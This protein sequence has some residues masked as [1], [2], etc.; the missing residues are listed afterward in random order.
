[1]QYNYIDRYLFDYCPDHFAFLTCFYICPFIRKEI[2]CLK[3]TSN[4]T[5][6]ALELLQLQNKL[7]RSVVVQ[8]LGTC[9]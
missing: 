1:M 9:F 3:V 7:K 6:T 5:N 2:L 4:V 8:W